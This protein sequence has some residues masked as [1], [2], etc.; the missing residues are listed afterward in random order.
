MSSNY[1]PVREDWLAIGAEQ[2]LEPELPLVDAHHHFYD[3]PGWSYLNTCTPAK[4]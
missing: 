4:G 3:R 1:L 2:A